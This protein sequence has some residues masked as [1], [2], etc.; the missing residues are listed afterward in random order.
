M[1]SVYKTQSMKYEDEIAKYMIE[2]NKLDVTLAEL[3]RQYE[4]YKVNRDLHIV[5]SGS[6]M[7]IFAASCVLGIFA[8]AVIAMVG[9]PYAIERTV[10][11]VNNTK[12]LKKQI[13]QTEKVAQDVQKHIEFL[14]SQKEFVDNQ[15]QVWEN[16]STQEISQENYTSVARKQMLNEDNWKNEQLDE[17]IQNA[18]I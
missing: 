10:S 7:A 11:Q 3:N 18:L 6:I 14:Q 16:Q 5:G 12:G 9:A 17:Q 15:I 4:Q 2:K 13:E 1:V 8:P